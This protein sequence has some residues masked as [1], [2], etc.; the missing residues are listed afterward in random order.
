MATARWVAQTESFAPRCRRANR[1]RAAAPRLDGS[2][3]VGHRSLVFGKTN[4]SELERRDDTLAFPSEEQRDPG[5][6]CSTPANAD[7]RVGRGAGAQARLL[8]L[9]K[10]AVLAH[11]LARRSL[12]SWTT[13]DSELERRDDTPAFPSEEER[14]PGQ[15][16]LDFRERRL[17]SWTSSERPQLNWTRVRLPGVSRT[18]GAS[19]V[20]AGAWSYLG[21]HHSAGVG[22]LPGANRPSRPPGASTRRREGR[23]GPRWAPLSRTTAR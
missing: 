5:S 16:S 10:G 6:A 14:D 21:S 11:R 22:Q 13:N 1:P 9:R 20:T 3:F 8:L 12:L 18:G 2:V 19:G 23:T 17:P 4:E 7:C 15:G